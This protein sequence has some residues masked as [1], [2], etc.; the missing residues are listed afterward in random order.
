MLS[1]CMLQL[2]TNMEIQSDAVSSLCIRVQ[3]NKEGMEF[4]G[5]YRLLVCVCVS[6]LAE[7][8][9]IIKKNTKYLLIDV[10]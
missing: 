10:K 3:E 7:N 1:I 4:N 8:I 9:N 2:K 5:T 6:L